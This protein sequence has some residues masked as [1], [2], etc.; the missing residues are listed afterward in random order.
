[1]MKKK[2]HNDLYWDMKNKDQIREQF[3]NFLKDEKLESNSHSA[4]LFAL[5]K[6]GSGYD[7][8]GLKKR[9]LILLLAG[10]L[11]EMYN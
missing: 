5:R 6:I 8:M 2:T 7:Y 4:H 11:P 1:M 10:E 9:D 3:N